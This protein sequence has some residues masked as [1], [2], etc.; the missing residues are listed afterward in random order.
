ML[1]GFALRAA[2][3]N[4]YIY[5]IT[6]PISNST[7]NLMQT[8]FRVQGVKGLI[9]ALHGVAV[10]DSYSAYNDEGEV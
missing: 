8:G 2:E 9:T 4:K 3:P 5:K 10:G 6:I 1:N 7:S